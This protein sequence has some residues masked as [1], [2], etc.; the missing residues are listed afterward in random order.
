M[1]VEAGTTGKPATAPAWR[2]RVRPR[3]AASLIL[4][5]EGPAG[6]TVLMGRR[7]LSARFMPGVYVCP[8]GRVADDDRRRWSGETGEAEGSAFRRLARAA[9][10]ETFEE[11]GILVGVKAPAGAAAAARFPI[12]AAYAAHGVVPDLSL[13]TYIGRAITPTAS[14]LRFDTRF[15]LA[16]ASYAVG[17][18][19]DSAELDDVAWHSA[20]PG[21][22]RPMSG[23]T[24]FMLARALAVWRGDTEPAPLYRHIGKRA[25]VGGRPVR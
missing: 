14:P 2:G 24:R 4:L 16:D 7:G 3:N 15:F 21:V 20:Y 5:R 18:H 6:L 10:R 12:E 13:L 8:G 19:A 17:G 1:M 25:Y 23:V 11:T 9:L 22:E